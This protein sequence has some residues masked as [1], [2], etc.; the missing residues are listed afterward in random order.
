MTSVE[1]RHDAS[2]IPLGEASREDILQARRRRIFSP[3]TL[4]LS[5]LIIVAMC[6]VTVVP[7]QLWIHQV[8]PDMPTTFESIHPTQGSYQGQFH[9]VE[10]D[11]RYLIGVG[12]AD[13]T[14]PVVDINLMG[15]ADPK[16]IG[17]GLQQ[18]LYSRAFIVGSLANPQDRWVY[19]VLDIQSGDTAIRYGVL[20]GLKALGPA[21][22]MYGHNNL[23]LSGTHSHS[24]PGAWLNYLLPQITSMG[25]DRQSYR[26]I[27]DGT[28]LSIRRAH[29]TLE[30]GH[31]SVGST[32]ISDASINRS[33]F[34]YLANPEEERA[35]Y[36]IS[37]QDDG[38]VEQDLTMLKMQRDSD[39]QNI[40]VL[41]WFPTHG[42]SMLGNNTIVSGDNKGVAADLLEKRLRGGRGVADGFVAGFSQAN[43]GDV[44]PNVLG[45]WCEDG[46]GE[47][48]SL[49]SST[50]KHGKGKKCHA[51]GPRFRDDDN[52]AASCFEIGKR[53][54]DGA[55]SLYES[56]SKQAPNLKGAVVKAA[57][58]FHNMA[59]FEFM[60][61]N[62]STAQTCPAALGY[63]FFA[64]TTDGPGLPH[65]IQHGSNSSN[66]PMPWN[67]LS[68]MLKRPGQDQ[69]RCQAPK[70]VILDV[71][72]VHIPYEWTPNIVDVQTLRVGHFFIIV[73][74]GE[75]TTMAGRRW[76]EAVA[77][78]SQRLFKDELGGEEPVVVIGGPSN[79]YS[80]YITT[81]E[82]Y[83]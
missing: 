15:Y 41:T 48:C 45:A 43:M 11:D 5:T 46:T 24:G 2:P 36:N 59:G 71:G 7:R 40:G 57:H 38:T 64:G 21:Y 29:E 54:S 72:E 14:G 42:T 30:P 74:T 19:L 18:R 4:C 10:G 31:L 47:R 34:S 69:V 80:H 50:C 56:L 39:G 8:H 78:Q 58:K 82:E 25:F 1:K 55:Y 70:P 23:A 79:T 9:A 53:Q 83:M 37:A 44:S 68:A 33:L 20:S 6:V 61:P 26:A 12:K 17:T 76:K 75:A 81:E 63:S 65:F 60:L 67:A 13:I 35:Q 32:K 22:A 62:G 52:G 77:Q 3:F 66:A 51:R 49:P 27:V 28:L 73:S 16:Q